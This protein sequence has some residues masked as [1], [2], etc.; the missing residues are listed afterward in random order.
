[1][2]LDGL[3]GFDMFWIVGGEELVHALY[4]AWP[5]SLFGV[6]H[7]QLEHKAWGGCG[8]L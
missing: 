7:L 6:L 2:S 5:A 3:R 8:V 4:K 1:M